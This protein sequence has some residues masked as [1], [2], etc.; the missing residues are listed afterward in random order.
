MSECRPVPGPL[1]LV[2]GGTGFIGARLVRDLAKDG[3]SVRV[4]ARHVDA[5]VGAYGVVEMMAG[6]VRDRQSVR[7][8]MEGVRWVFHLAGKAHDL[9]EMGD[10]TAHDE[11]TVKGTQHV[12]DEA[13]A[14]GVERFVFL[15]SLAVYKAEQRQLDESA[16][17]AP[18][19]AYGRA[20]LEAQRYVLTRA[21]AIH[22]SCLQPAMVY[23][24]GCKGNLPRMMAMI[25]RGWFPPVPDV[26]NRRS[27]AFLVDVVRAIRLAAQHAAANGQCFIVTD[28]ECYS[29]KRIYEAVCRG[30]NRNV[31]R[32][33]V[34]ASAFRFLARVGDFYGT[35]RHKRFPFDSH[36]YDKLFG[37]AW[38]SGD[39]IRRELAFE[40]S[41]TLESAMPLLL[42]RSNRGAR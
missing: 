21:R 31:P 10:S 4:F 15:S 32:W 6:D 19:T 33:C 8:A 39:K 17:C 37:S 34:P 40:P 30:L 26:A 36:A 23:G 35:L 29:T 18:S 9:S 27:L 5:A 7:R 3:M 28:G 25:Q 1:A 11:I 20:K 38:F 42:D 13:V 24:P 22:V 41:A 2:T 12:V 14:H 16:I